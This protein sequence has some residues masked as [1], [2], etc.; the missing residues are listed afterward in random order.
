MRYKE[1]CAREE[2]AEEMDIVIQH[3]RY[4]NE[5]AVGDLGMDNVIS[6]NLK[7]IKMPKIKTILGIVSILG[8]FIGKK[9][10]DIM[11]LFTKEGFQ[12]VK[13]F[14]MNDVLGSPEIRQ[15]VDRL[16]G[17]G[18]NEMEAIVKDFLKKDP[19]LFDSL[20]NVASRIF[21]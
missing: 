17:A 20:K 4:L 6:K 13:D 8:K 16:I 3:H 7:N 2:L 10:R 12:K 1:F 18:Y 15:L 11:K 5:E 19:K 9:P 14:I 21:A